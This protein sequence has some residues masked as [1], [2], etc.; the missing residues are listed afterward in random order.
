M[1]WIPK[2]AKFRYNGK[3]VVRR[4]NKC[5]TPLGQFKVYEAV[6]GNVF[7]EHPF[8]QGSGGLPGYNPDPN[9]DF[10]SLKIKVASMEEG[11]KKCEAKW[12]QVKQAINDI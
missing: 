1:K 7:I 10:G 4:T 5:D 12:L 3:P 11:V 2:E 9:D 6:S 8:I